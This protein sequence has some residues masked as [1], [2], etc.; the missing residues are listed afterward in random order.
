MRDAARPAGEHT[1]PAAMPKVSVVT[2]SLNQ[3]RFLEAAIRSVLDQD[4][5]N[6]EYIIVDAGSTDGSRDI[7]ERYRSRF[8]RVI[9]EADEGPGSGLN[10]GFAAASGDIFAYL[11]SDDVLLPG[12]IGKAVAAFAAEPA[13]AVVYAHGY[14]IDENGR[15]LRR[16][17]SAPFD[18]WRHAFGAAVIVQQTT[19]IRRDAFVAAGGFNPE[20]YSCWDAELLVDIALA[21]GAFRCVDDYWA[22]FR[23]HRSSLT[24]S[25]S[26]AT[27]LEADEDRIFR[28]IMGRGRR[29][30]DR[31]WAMA[32]RLAKWAH[33]PRSF[34]IRLAETSLAAAVSAPK[35]R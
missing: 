23:L 4:Y 30:S 29:R 34:L 22:L 3:A 13:A 6:L 8:A 27:Q 33:D 19:F 31:F 26:R 16:L 7:I 14:L 17:R 10:K 25:K 9:F 21:G 28:K 18:L 2:T 12:A 20:N 1:S 15:A 11:N 24:G 5:A 35:L 32:A